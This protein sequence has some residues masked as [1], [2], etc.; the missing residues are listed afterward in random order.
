MEGLGKRLNLCCETLN[1]TL[2]KVC[3]IN[4]VTFSAIK[5]DTQFERQ[6]HRRNRDRSP[7]HSQR[8]RCSLV[9]RCS[10]TA[11]QPRSLA[12]SLALTGSHWF[13]GYSCSIDSDADCR[14]QRHRVTVHSIS[15]SFLHPSSPSSPSSVTYRRSPWHAQRRTH[16]SLRHCS[17]H[18]PWRCVF[19]P[20]TRVCNLQLPTNCCTNLH[21]Q[22]S[23][24]SHLIAPILF[25]EC[26]LHAPLTPLK[27]MPIAPCARL[28]P[29]SPHHPFSLTSASEHPSRFALLFHP[30][31]SPAVASPRPQHR[32]RNMQSSPSSS[33]LPSLPPLVAILLAQSN[34][35][36]PCQQLP[37]P[38]QLSPP[39]RHHVRYRL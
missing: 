12:R 33:S 31:D 34:A 24:H 37:P 14:L 4:D 3:S 13:S 35:H 8:P 7:I 32:K 18:H 15:N 20:R 17:I 30:V 36:H 26:C 19:H 6:R 5:S 16:N 38:H 23:H 39:S 25:T 28:C 11:L 9:V 1:F 29:P 22:L 10:S 27:C 21:L 2:V